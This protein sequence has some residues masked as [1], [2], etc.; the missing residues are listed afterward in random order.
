MSAKF[1]RTLLK[2]IRP[3]PSMPLRPKT[4]NGA[5][6]IQTGCKNL[7]V[8]C[9]TGVQKVSRKICRDMIGLTGHWVEDAELPIPGVV[10]QSRRNKNLSILIY[11]ICC[12]R[13]VSHSHVCSNLDFFFGSRCHEHPK[14]TH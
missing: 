2:P 3:G 8:G 5:F 14:E 13:N 12:Q 10:I 6:R 11:G 9:P 1:A 7:P 4:P